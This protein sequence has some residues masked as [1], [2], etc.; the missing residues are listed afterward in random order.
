[1]AWIE[2]HQDLMN[3]PKVF[4]IM[5]KMKWSQY[6]TIGRL[7]CFWWWCMTYAEDGDLSKYRDTQIAAAVGVPNDKAA[8]FM[9]AM[10]EAKFIDKK[11][12]SIRVHDW[13]DY[14]GRYLQSR[15]GK[16]PEKW[17]KV[18]GRYKTVNSKSD[19]SQLVKCRNPNAPNLTI[20]N[21]TIR[22]PLPPEGD[23]LFENF[24]KAYPKKR[25]KDA[26]ARSWSRRKLDGEAGVIMAALENHKKNA[27]WRREG[28]RFIPNPATWLNEGRWKDEIPEKKAASTRHE[29]EDEKKDHVDLEKL[30]D[31]I[32]I[33][34]GREGGGGK[35]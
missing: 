35:Q 18:A 25:G 20:P 28:G 3:H 14:A 32:G 4:E 29:W 26:A 7:H 5:E 22:T 13:W 23:G 34:A 2:S 8:E 31:T 11:G 33:G 1:M 15:Y 27:D 17:R 21:H 24:W 19:G 12:N 6:E 10:I 16:D 30:A 9:V